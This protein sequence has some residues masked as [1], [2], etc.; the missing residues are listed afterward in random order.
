MFCLDVCH[1]L[2]FYRE[3]LVEPISHNNSL[4]IFV[5]FRDFW[6]LCWNLDIFWESTCSGKKKESEADG[7]TLIFKHFSSGYKIEAVDYKLGAPEL[8]KFEKP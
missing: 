6:I 8:Y 3:V 4:I 2:Q 1:V 5:Y 7:N